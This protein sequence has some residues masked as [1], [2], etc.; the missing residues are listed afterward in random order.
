M[1]LTGS[2]TST[3]RTSTIWI[4]VYLVISANSMTFRESP[5]KTTRGSTESLIERGNLLKMLKQA[6]LLARVSHKLAIDKD[7][8]R[9]VTKRFLYWTW[10]R[11][12]WEEHQLN[13]R[14]STSL[15]IIVTS[16]RQ[17]QDC[18]THQGNLAIQARV[19]QAALS[20]SRTMILYKWTASSSRRSLRLVVALLF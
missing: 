4:L 11:E 8:W 9:V 13:S 3:L 7:F 20:A 15:C 16:H 17:P 19:G 5:S 1:L 12:S 18:Y 10:T 6:S 2:A 14:W